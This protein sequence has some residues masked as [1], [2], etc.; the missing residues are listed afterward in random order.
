MFYSRSSR[1]LRLRTHL[2][3]SSLVSTPARSIRRWNSTNKH[4]ELSL[5]SLDLDLTEIEKPK[6]LNNSIDSQDPLVDSLVA[7]PFN[8]LSKNDILTDFLRDTKHDEP[9]GPFDKILEDLGLDD[10]SELSKKDEGWREGAGEAN[11][12]LDQH[13]DLEDIVKQE[14][15]LFESIFSKYSMKEDSETNDNTKYDLPELVLSTLNKSYTTPVKPSKWSF[16]SPQPTAQA[17]EEE[18]LTRTKSALQETLEHISSLGSRSELMEFSRQFFS[19]YLSN[20]YDK[21]TFVLRKRRDE[22]SDDYLNRQKAVC[23][24]IEDVSHLTPE[25]PLLTSLT[26]PILMNH[27]ITTFL[28]KFYDASLALT[29]FNCSKENLGLYTVVCDQTTYNEILKVYWVFY[30]KASLY[31]V[32]LIIVEMI[33]NGFRGDAQTFAILNEILK[34]YHTMRM[35]QSVYNPRGSPIWCE[36]DERRARNLGSQLRKIGSHLK[37]R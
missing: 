12:E 26:M 29:L 6:D 34:S 30:G 10:Y 23:R 27:I 16:F 20:D 19:R 8:E 25:A 15:D 4:D 32:E 2:H 11:D 18:Q 24:E 5:F 33:N 31:E 1:L 14:K 36:E 7:L 37:A 9:V 22:S 17:S 35:G 28:T 13:V 21:D 3:C